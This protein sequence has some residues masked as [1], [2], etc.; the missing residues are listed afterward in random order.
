[1]VIHAG[2]KKFE[3]L[4]IRSNVNKAYRQDLVA[5]GV[6]NAVNNEQLLQY[7]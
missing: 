5:L 4:M 6:F 2:W 7:L 3:P 1:M